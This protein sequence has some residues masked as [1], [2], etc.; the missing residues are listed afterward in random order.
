MC[1]SSVFVSCPN[2]YFYAKY[3]LLYVKVSVLLSNGL[4]L[5]PEYFSGYV[6][7]SAVPYSCRGE[8]CARE[9]H[10]AKL[11]GGVDSNGWG[12]AGV[13]KKISAQD[14]YCANSNTKPDSQ[15]SYWA[16]KVVGNRAPLS[17]REYNLMTAI[18]IRPLTQPLTCEM[19]SSIFAPM[20][21][22]K[23]E[24]KTW[25]YLPIIP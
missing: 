6:S 3:R 22:P 5:M 12:C 10:C 21:W 2:P 17:I 4:L 14:I 23:V 20:S 1:V 13:H 15:S 11:V 25:A 24:S 18:S 7:V 16:H 8:C 9:A 19:G